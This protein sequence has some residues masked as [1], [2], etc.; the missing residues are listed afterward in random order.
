MHKSFPPPMPAATVTPDDNRYVHLTSRGV[1]PRFR[2]SPEYVRVV[3]STEQ[4]VDTVS[5]AVRDGKRI[6]VRSGGHGFENFID[7]P[8]VQ[9]VV[10]MSGMTNV[11]FDERHKAFAVEPGITLGEAYRRL[12]LGWGVTMPAGICVDVGVGGHILGGGYGP[13]SRLHGLVVDHLY[14]VEV[15]VV[16]A[17]GHAK[18]IVATRDESD[19]NRELWWAHTGG[20]GGNFGIVTRYLLRSPGVDSHDAADLL[21]KAPKMS[22]GFSLTWSWENLDR[23]SFE[24][25][26]RN[27]G[28]WHENNSA[29]DSPYI[30]LNSLLMAFER[31]VGHVQLAG[32]IIADDEGAPGRLEDYIGAVTDGVSAPFQRVGGMAPWLD[33]TLSVPVAEVNAQT[34]TKT[35]SGY[36]RKRFSDEQIA[37]IYDNL[38]GGRKD[39]AGMLWQFSYGG[40][41]GAASPTETACAQ[42]DSI[43]KAVFI[44]GWMD[45]SVD[46][47]NLEWLRRFYREVYAES[48]GVPASN[49]RTD[50]C[51]INYADVDLVDPDLNGS[52]IPWHRLYYKDNYPRLQQAKARWDPRD[53][54]RHGLGIRPADG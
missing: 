50:G 7:N 11:Y 40:K 34:R 14:G 27:H 47:S 30:G 16:D 19:P 15:V 36:M 53:V 8:E 43:L 23:P 51:F 33:A 25:L 6:A 24:R 54:F 44:G 18:A 29:P 35:K 38:S 52:G 20:G 2:G 5:E 13:L 12:Y 48:G 49:D 1:N 31:Q 41:V 28:E 26:L 32:Q 3:G 4:V 39:G 9:V 37:V 17:S 46:D 45:P 10:D 42:R 21:P 22:L